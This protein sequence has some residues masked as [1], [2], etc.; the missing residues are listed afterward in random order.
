MCSALC[1]GFWL[2]RFYYS[3]LPR[4]TILMKI[5]WDFYELHHKRMLGGDMEFTVSSLDEMEDETGLAH[6]LSY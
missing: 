3:W 2:I 5:K 1:E 6:P 4:I